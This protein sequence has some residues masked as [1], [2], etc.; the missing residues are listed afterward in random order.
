MDSPEQRWR[1]VVTAPHL[2]PEALAQ[3][4]AA[5]IVYTG[6]TTDAQTIVE[7]CARH[8][9]HGLLVRLGRVDRR[10]ID[11]A[12]SLR[13]IAR[14]GSG[15]DTLDLAHAAA[16]GIAWRTTAGT[17]AV[18]VAEHALALLLACA[19][20]I[21]QLNRRLHAG[22]WDKHGHMGMQLAGSTLGI[23][24]MGAIGTRMAGLAQALGMHVVAAARPADAGQ[25]SDGVARLPLDALWDA[26]DAISLHCPL[27]PRTARL[28]NA[29][30]LARCRPG[31]ILV[32]TG[33]GGL[34]DDA[35]LVTALR[36]GRVAAA[37]LDT[38]MDEPLE[39]GHPYAGLDNAILSPH[40]GAATPQAWL[41]ACCSA[42]GQ[43]AAMLRAG[44]VSPP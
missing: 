6:T 3:L 44:A 18:A 43:L 39:A 20:S 25:A 35:A 14:H 21:P 38:F 33:R 37:G 1:I 28:V 29:D 2:P 41:A 27:T 9:P 10:V 30:S 8:D 17:N 36:T 12:P 13:A 7:A 23:V 42:A 22:H 31:M 40:V 24:G 26:C 34:V 11:A 15:T 19:K 4:T 16:R 32:N 5:D